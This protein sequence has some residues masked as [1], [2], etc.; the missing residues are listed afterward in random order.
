MAKAKLITNPEIINVK[1]GVEKTIRNIIIILIVVVIAYV[2][3]S[4]YKAAKRGGKIIG[5]GAGGIIIQQQTGITP[6]RQ[7]VCKDVAKAC[8]KAMI[9]DYEATWMGLWWKRS[10]EDEDAVISNLNRLVTKNEVS[11]VCEE[12]ELLPESRNLKS[13]VKSYLNSSEQN[14]IKKLVRDNLY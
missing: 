4:L 5:E 14:Q 9:G 1:S 13:D 3:Y 6:A 8:F 2:L 10:D 7:Q 11:L 12:Y